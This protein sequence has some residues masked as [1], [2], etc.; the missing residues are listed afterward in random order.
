M[1]GEDLFKKCQVQLC[2]GRIL[3]TSVITICLG[4]LLPYCQHNTCRNDL[5]SFPS[6]PSINPS[7]I[8]TISSIAIVAE[9]HNK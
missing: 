5:S 8:L 2:N 6:K 1:Q 7:Y 9:D 3:K 4:E